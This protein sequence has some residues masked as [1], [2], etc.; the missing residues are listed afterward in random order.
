VSGTPTLVQSR[1]GHQGN[2]ELLVPLAS[3][4]LAHFFR[5]N[6]T[7]GFP[8]HGPTMILDPKTQYLDASMIQS[9][10]GD[11]HDLEVIATLSSS[12]TF[13]F[14]D[15]NFQWNGPFPLAPDGPLASS[16]IFPGGGNPVLIQSTFGSARAN[17]ELLGIEATL[18]GPGPMWHAFRDND[19]SC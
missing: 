3:G 15:Q 10:Y 16:G 13:F 2:F 19:H 17:F 5:D 18:T 1:N 7:P 11:G 4:G 8:W 14:R 9:S 12:L 6:D